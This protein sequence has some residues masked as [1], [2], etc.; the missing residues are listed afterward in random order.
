MLHSYNRVST[1]PAPTE[2]GFPFAEIISYLVGIIRQKYL[3]ILS[4]AILTTAIAVFYVYIT[5]P[6]YT[7]RATMIIDKGKAQV[8]L[9]GVVNEVPIE[10]ESQLQVLTSETVRLAV[11]GKFD[12]ANDP[13]FVG[14]PTG[15][16]ALIQKVVSLVRPSS[17]SEAAEDATRVALRHLL[18]RVKLMRSNYVVEIDFSSLKPERAA[19]IANAFAECYIEEQLKSK[20]QAAEQAGGWLKEQIKELREQSLRAD[21]AVTEFKAKYNIV[22][23]DGRLIGDQEIALLNNQVVIAREK[24]AEARARLDRIESIIN[25]KAPDRQVMATV[26]DTL[27]NP[28]I[29]K[30]RTQY[31]EFTNR[32]AVWSREH[33]ED[34]QAVINLRRQIREILASIEDELRRIGETYKSEYQIARQRQAELEKAVADAVVQSKETNQALSTLRNLE[35]SAETLRTLYRT[36]LQRGTELIQ[37]QSFPGAEARLITRA[38]TPTG[39]SSPKTLLVMSA[40]L[41]GGLL[42]GFG[43]GA[44]ICSLDR[45]FRTPAQVEAVLQARC[46]ALAPAVRG[47]RKKGTPPPPYPGSRIIQREASVAFNVLDQPLSRFAE[48]MRSIKAEA[49]VSGPKKAV[50]V[51][52]FTSSLPKEGKS[53]VATAFALLA[54][55][56]GSRVILVD[57]DLRNPA[58]SATLAPSAEAGLIEVLSGHRQLDEVLW[59]VST[60]GLAFLPAVMPKARL[61]DSSTILASAPL[62]S[63]FEKLR[64]KYDYVVVD[65]SPAAPIMDV[66][67]TADLVDSYVFIVEWGQT[68]MDVA[69]LSLRNAS[70]VRDNLLGVVLNKVDFRTLGRYEG[71]RRDYYAD[72]HYAQYGQV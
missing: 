38:S 52:G 45:V 13:E 17:S 62:R 2:A 41:L 32:E 58:L 68:K 15:V 43:A 22:S 35:S 61:A 42:L 27:N 30:L 50:T 25:A 49:K 6:T 70:A 33:G 1:D 63:F 53:T 60:S 65:L 20:Q 44:V 72:K 5:P 14:P 26:S 10:V 40:S 46:L 36:A 29:V 48:A 31:L 55:Q 19:A 9:G 47:N 12:L 34:H 54:A 28:I 69:D 18:E 67:L 3:L 16:R 37:M 24:T 51:L 21:E 56:A 8:K 4:T 64:E 66:R 7:A 23:A 59:S 39:K 11:V 71:Y 57:C